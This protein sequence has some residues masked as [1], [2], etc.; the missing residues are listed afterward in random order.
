MTGKPLPRDNPMPDE[1]ETPRPDRCETCRFFFVDADYGH[2]IS[3]AAFCRRYPPVI[4]LLSVRAALIE[5]GERTDDTSAVS[6][7]SDQC[8]VWQ[9]PTVDANHWCGEWK[10]KTSNR[11]EWGAFCQSL[12]SRVF[13]VFE[14]EQVDSWDTLLSTSWDDMYGW[15]NFGHTSLQELRKQIVRAGAEPPKDWPSGWPS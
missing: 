12:S 15:R 10:V 8:H 13:N 14:K 7:W 3:Q 4:N 5:E 9:T 11:M 2:S 6:C 1:Q